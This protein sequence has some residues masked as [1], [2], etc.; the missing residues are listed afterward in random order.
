MTQKHIPACV[1]ATQVLLGRVGARAVFPSPASKPECKAALP[2]LCGG[3]VAHPRGY[4]WS[5]VCGG[6]VGP[7]PEMCTLVRVPPPRYCLA[8]WVCV[9]H[10]VFWLFWCEFHYPGTAWQSGYVLAAM[11]SPIS[12]QVPVPGPGTAW[13]GGRGCV[14]CCIFSLFYYQR[15]RKIM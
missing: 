15:Y 13:Q 9:R 5:I 3:F 7:V 8:G 4:R 6:G 11:F 1:S 2:L 12:V 14:R 10:R